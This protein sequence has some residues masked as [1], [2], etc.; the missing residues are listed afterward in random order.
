MILHSCLAFCTSEVFGGP[1]FAVIDDFGLVDCASEDSCLRLGSN[2][3]GL[4][5]VHRPGEASFEWGQDSKNLLKYFKLERQGQDI[6]EKKRRV[7]T[8]LGLLR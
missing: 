2:Y 8:I 3:L 7:E 6:F 1:G 5:W 4:T